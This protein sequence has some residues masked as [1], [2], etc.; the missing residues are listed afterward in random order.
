MNETDKFDAW[1]AIKTFYT[2][3]FGV[4]PDLVDIL[5]VFDVLKLCASGACNMSIS[6]FLYI[7]EQATINILDAYLGFTGW[8][9]D[10]SFSPLGLYKELGNPD[11]A[12]FVDNV[13]TKYGYTVDID[14]HRMYE[15]ARHVERL[16][17]L[18]DEKW[19]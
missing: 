1:E 11:E 2:D 17:R 18:L 10:L 7:E 5:S 3:K 16:E 13:I 8:E 4:S 9:T 6:D 14:L 15:S 12:T 19:V